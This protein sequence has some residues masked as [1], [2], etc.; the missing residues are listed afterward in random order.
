MVET[1][2]PEAGTTPPECNSSFL[3]PSKLHGGTVEL[4]HLLW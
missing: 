3:Q 2:S 1:L 4:R